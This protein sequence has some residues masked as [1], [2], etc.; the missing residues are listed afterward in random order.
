MMKGQVSIFEVISVILIVIIA[1]SIF[2]PGITYENRWDD[3]SITQKGRDVVIT[4]DNIKA[5]PSL[6][7]SSDSLRNY[8]DSV[9]PQ[10]NFIY[11]TTT[12]GAVPSRITVACN[13]TDQQISDLIFWVG[14]MRVNG[15]DFDIDFVKSPLD[16]IQRSDALFIWQSGSNSN[17]SPF[18][19]Q[20][21]SYMREGN[22]VI[23]M[24]DHSSAVDA[25][26]REIFGISECSSILPNCQIAPGD[27]TFVKPSTFSSANYQVYKIFH[28]MPMTLRADIDFPETIQLNG[29]TQSCGSTKFA[30]GNFL[31]RDNSLQYWVCGET[32]SVYANTD[33]GDPDADVVYAERDEFSHLGYNFM[34]NYAD[35]NRTYV[36]FK[37]DYSLSGLSGN[38][39]FP[40]NLDTS[41]IV[42]QRGNFGGSSNPVP[43]MV[44]NNTI[45]TPAIWMEDLSDSGTTDDERMLL[46][47]AI[48]SAANK[49]PRDIGIARL[50]VGVLTSYVYANNTDMFESYIFNLGLGF[51][52]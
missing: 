4:A 20:I 32:K 37:P 22:G 51:P 39:V 29:E 6:A 10:R 34:L 1:F 49:Q 18:R 5:I 16:P 26:R 41:R 21:L 25:T 38:P 3:A 48:V 42:V 46:A 40:S 33:S 35:N 43:S 13:C 31:F 45:G 28:G 27:A 15:R 12:D 47:S 19:T 23:E 14:R 17:L 44:V 36:S 7:F 50:R 24:R 30:E 9:I 11:W 2:F 8:I 52:F